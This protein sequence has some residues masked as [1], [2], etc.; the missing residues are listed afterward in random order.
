MSD[1]L[2]LG[3]IGSGNIGG[4]LARLAVDAGLN[5]V[6][7]NSRSPET[8]ADL[9]ADLGPRARAATP[10]EAAAAADW[11][12]V[13]VPLKHQRQIP[14]AP[15]AGKV[16]LDA[17][18]YYPERDGSI[19]ELD[20]EQVTTSELLQRH[21]TGSEVVKAFNNIWV[22]HLASLARPSG[23]PDRSVLPIAGDAP[24]AKAA[25]T[26]LIDLLG[27]DT[28]DTGPLAGSWRFQRD[29]PAYV[30]LY[31]KDQR[32]MT[33]EDPGGTVT[34]DELRAAL[35]AARRQSA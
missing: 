30:G 11:V 13:A 29:T 33:A 9:V 24:D 21:L 14:V 18:N 26:R 16:V 27:Y 32:E 34:A 12:V 25:A 28:L 6:L 2:T 10:S 5:V 3:L 35:A 22:N 4:A 23:A 31:F 7:S 8:L 17:T 15:L 19:A 20:A 1:Q